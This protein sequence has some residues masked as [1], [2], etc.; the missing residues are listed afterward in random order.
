MVDFL[1]NAAASEHMSGQNIAFDGGFTRRYWILP[2]SYV[3]APVTQK[4]LY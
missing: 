3:G 4:Q 1:I 2:H